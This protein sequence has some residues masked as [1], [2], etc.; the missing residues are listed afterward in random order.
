MVVINL[1][2]GYLSVITSKVVIPNKEPDIETVKELF[3]QGF[4]ILDYNLTTSF[5]RCLG[6][7]HPILSGVK[8]NSTE[9]S[10][11]FL[12]VDSCPETHNVLCI[13]KWAGLGTGLLYTM[14]K[15]RSILEVQFMFKL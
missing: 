3:H 8:V 7:W 15:E 10:D 13:A 11:L 2:I 5:T 9:V 1:N 12:Q 4:R 14:N 6:F